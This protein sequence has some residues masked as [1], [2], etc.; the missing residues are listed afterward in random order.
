MVLEISQPGFVWL[1]G[2]LVEYNAAKINVDS[3]ISLGICERMRSYPCAE[4]LKE[5]TLLLKFDDHLDNFYNSAK[6]LGLGVGKRI[7]KDG[8]R[9]AV[10]ETIRAN[11]FRTYSDI[12]VFAWPSCAGD[13][14][15]VAIVVKSYESIIS[16]DDFD[17]GKK[18]GIVALKAQL[19]DSLLKAKVT[20]GYIND[21]L[22]TWEAKAKGLYGSLFVD[23][24]GS[25]FGGNYTFLAV[26]KNGAVVMQPFPSAMKDTIRDAVITI[27]KDQGISVAERNIAKAELLGA[28]EAFVCG[29]DVE[30]VPIAEVDGK[31]IGGGKLGSVTEQIAKRF[32]D[33]TTA[34]SDRYLDWL[35][36]VY[37]E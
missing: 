29:V 6:A 36:T 18:F 25:V 2:E 1:N 32:T 27:A 21:V 24:Q 37:A 26:V 23:S 10:L 14:P 15:D 12:S 33:A 3:K 5:N 22:G 35:T 7:N 31:A 30:I 9:E 20:A 17:K 8:L 16:S 19:F 28:D 4:I 13:V 34:R 11:E